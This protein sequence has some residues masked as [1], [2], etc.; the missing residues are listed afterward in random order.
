MIYKVKRFSQIIEKLFGK[1]NEPINVVQDIYMETIKSV[2]MWRS[3]S[4]NKGN[5]GVNTPH[6]INHLT[7]KMWDIGDKP[8]YTFQCFYMPLDNNVNNIKGKAGVF[9]RDY[10]KGRSPEKIIKDEINYVLNLKEGGVNKYRSTINSQKG[11]SRTPKDYLYFFK[12]LALSLSGQY[13]GGPWDNTNFIDRTNVDY[14]KQGLRFNSPSELQ[15][16][17][18][19]LFVEYLGPNDFIEG[20]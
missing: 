1:S 2:E 5:S 18:E 9:G 4:D 11:I 10:S 14:T 19:H 8:G 16:Y 13:S 20:F 12:Y 15:K 3:F 7:D 17:L 6:W